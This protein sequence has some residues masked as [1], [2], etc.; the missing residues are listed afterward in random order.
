M[1]RFLTTLFVT[2]SIATAASAQNMSGMDGM[3][4]QQMMVQM[5]K[6]QQCLM[7]VDESTLRDYE[8]R[9]YKLDPELKTLCKAGKRDEAQ[10]KAI[11]FGKEVARS[12]AFKTI[13]ACTKNMQ[14][15]AFMPALPDFDNL[16]KLHI[17]EELPKLLP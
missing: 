1:Y 3:N 11:K 13:Q 2:L 14:A 8:R 17:C 4:M 15:N 10:Q 9:I 5:N 16:D 6:M 7:Q 12:D